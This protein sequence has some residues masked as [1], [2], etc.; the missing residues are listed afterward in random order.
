MR[1]LSRIK[2]VVASLRSDVPSQGAQSRRSHLWT[3]MSNFLE[4]FAEL[5]FT[6]NYRERAPCLR[7]V[8]VASLPCA[9]TATLPAHAMRIAPAA[10]RHSLAIKTFSKQDP[11]PKHRSV[12]PRSRRQ[13][14]TPRYAL[15]VRST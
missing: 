3:M 7:T 6:Q 13:L 12:R 2:H 8:P 4:L 5:L 14:A 11:Q 15:L 1:Y 10:S 9:T